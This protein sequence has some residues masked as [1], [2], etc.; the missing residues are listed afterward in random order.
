MLIWR[1]TFDLP[2]QLSEAGSVSNIKTLGTHSQADSKVQNFYAND[3]LLR[4]VTKANVIALL[5]E[6][7]G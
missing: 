1:E 7:H 3:S 2:H 5:Q 6:Q 4:V